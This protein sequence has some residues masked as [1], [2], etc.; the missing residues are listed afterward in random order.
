MALVVGVN[1]WVTQAEADTYFEDRIETA[2]WD[3][4]SST[5]KD[6]YLVTAYRWLFYHP[7]ISA[8]ASTSAPQGVKDG[9]CEAALFL[10]N[11]YDDYTKREALY[12]SGVRKFTKSKWSEELAN[13]TLPSSITDPIDEEG[14]YDG[15]CAA[16]MDITSDTDVCY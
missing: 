6:K 7:A 11:Y 12:S 16:M 4:L 13:V 14:Y 8:P 15:G 10:I 2:P 1:S 3:A 5:D 9:Q